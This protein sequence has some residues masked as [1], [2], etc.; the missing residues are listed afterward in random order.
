M[1]VC[2]YVCMYVSQREYITVGCE[3]KDQPGRIIKVKSNKVDEIL[4][5]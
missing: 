5:N 4:E 1:Y 2:M 3:Q